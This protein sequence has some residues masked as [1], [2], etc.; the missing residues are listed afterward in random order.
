VDCGKRHTL[1]VDAGGATWVCGDNQFRQL[2]LPHSEKVFEMKRL[3]DFPFKVKR[4][5]AGIDH[6][7]LL[8]EDNQIFACGSNLDGNLGLG[9]NYSCDSFLQV[10]GINNVQIKNIAAGRHS[11]AIST[12]GR[13][14]VWGPVFLGDKPL[15]IP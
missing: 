8:T 6:S 9:H 1:A 4:T 13:L 5:A 14:Y 2:G 12:D 7:L 15:L 10:H 3:T 11:A